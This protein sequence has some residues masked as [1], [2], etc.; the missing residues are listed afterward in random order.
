MMLIGLIA[1]THIPD[2]AKELPAQLKEVF[3][4]VDRI[5]HA[6]DIYSL[7]VLNELEAISPVLA[8]RGDD[9]MSNTA[10]D[11]RVKSKHVMGIDGVTVWLMHERPKKMPRVS[12]EISWLD[13]PPDV[14]V[15]GHTHQSLIEEYEGVLYVNP[16]SPTFP[17][18]K[19]EPGTVGLLSIDNGKVEAE[20]V[21][22]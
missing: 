19:L 22:L 4:G 20:I 18:Y 1:D 17:G 13:D 16:G 8:A 3:K 21:Q 15:Y 14:I 10:S 11:N 9:D 5:F 12:K 6:G 2:H 7:S